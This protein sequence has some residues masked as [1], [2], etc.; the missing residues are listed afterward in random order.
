MGVELPDGEGEDSVSNLPLLQGRTDAPVRDF[1]VHH[2]GSGR[3]AIRKGDWVFIDAPNG[4][5]NGEPDWFKKERGYT[6][7]GFPGELFDLGDDIAERTNLY[8]EHPRVVRELSELL[9]QVKLDGGTAELSFE[10]QG[11]SE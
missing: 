10:S 8:G 5:D 11:I 4:D 2:S 7:H 9:N 1:V 6:S 3:F